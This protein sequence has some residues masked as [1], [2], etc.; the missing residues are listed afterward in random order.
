MY[1][2]RTG[3]EH[4][5]CVPALRAYL[6]SGWAELGALVEP[7]LAPLYQPWYDVPVEPAHAYNARRIADGGPGGD[8][9]AD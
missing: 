1:Y 6:D 9:G 7:Y 8:R 3:M 2:G 4:F 5:G